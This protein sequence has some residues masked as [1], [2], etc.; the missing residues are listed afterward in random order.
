LAG[1]SWLSK[2]RW[3]PFHINNPRP[4]ST[5][6]NRP[7]WPGNCRC[8]GHLIREGSCS[9]RNFKLQVSLQ[10]FPFSHAKARNSHPQQTLYEFEILTSSQSECHETCQ[11]LLIRPSKPDVVKVLGTAL[12]NSALCSGKRE[13]IKK[14]RAY[15]AAHGLW[16]L[17]LVCT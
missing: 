6:A 10:G 16:S 11:S 5:A 17:R 7:V 3:M 1:A 12:I 14:E 15:L 13:G 2:A 4:D 8:F 9:R